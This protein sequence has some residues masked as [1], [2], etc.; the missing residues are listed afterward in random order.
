[1]AEDFWTR[2]VREVQDEITEQVQ[3]SI[4]CDPVKLRVDEER[5]AWLEIDLSAIEH[6]ISE[7]RKRLDQKTRLMA[8]VKAN[9][10]GHGAIQVARAAL[11]CGA[12]HLGVATVQEGVELRQAGIVD[13]ILVLAQP[14]YA[15]IPALLDYDLI[16]A[17]H[18]VEFALA[19]GEQ[20]DTRG[21]VAKYHLKINTGMNRVGVQPSEVLDFMRMTDFHRGLALDGV[22][23]HF[24]TADEKEDYEFSLQ[25]K[26]FIE[27]INAMRAAGFATGI[28]HCANSAAAVRYRQTQF[29]MVRLGIIM[30]GLHPGDTTKR[31][32]NLHPAMA[33]RGRINALNEVPVGEGVS[34]GLTYRS[35]GNVIIATVPLGYADG[36]ARNLSNQMQVLYQGRPLNQVGT[37]CMDQFM[38]EIDRRHSPL[39]KTRPP[40]IGDL[41]TIV[42]RDGDE[43]L[44]LDAMAAQLGTI[45][46]ELACHFGLRLAR[47]FVN[48][49]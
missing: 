44:T 21:I 45:N 26:R 13:P 24:A 16:P 22:F 2:A 11:R 3:T 10:Y 9:A 47:I 12:S 8:V 4:P 18:A 23:T 5:W 48:G 41:V 27:S 42:G 36:L 37:I 35:P 15:A 14:P 33:V 39:V 43:E 6:N 29:D 25:L 28:V 17:V 31:F 20:A 7:V 40:K 32:V 1:M 46:Y 38:F 49:R 34:Y 19:L 30:Y